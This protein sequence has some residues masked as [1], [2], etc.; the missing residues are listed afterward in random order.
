MARRA[1]EAQRCALRSSKR[2]GILI[3]P[4]SDHIRFQF[5]ARWSAALVAACK[6]TPGMSWNPDDAEDREDRTWVGYS[7]AIEVVCDKL[8]KDGLK[9]PSWRRDAHPQPKLP[10]PDYSQ[11]RDYQKTC[12]DFLITHAEQGALLAADMRLGKSLCALRAAEAISPENGIL[13]SAHPTLIICPSHVVGV[14]A[15]SLPTRPCEIKRWLGRN[16]AESTL[17]LE[18]TKP[19]L[20]H[21]DIR[22]R[23]RFVVIHFDILHAWAEVLQKVK[24]ITV[25]V[26]EIHAFQNEN[27]RRSQAGAAIMARAPF[28]IGLSGTPMTN[29]P[30]DLYSV[31]NILSPDRFGSNFF[32][33]GMSYCDGHK[34]TVGRGENQKVVYNFDGRSNAD[35]L[36]KR[37][38][39]FMLRVKKTDVM[40]QL[41]Q[42]ARQ[43]INVEIPRRNRLVPSQEHLKDK[44]L[45][46][47]LLDASADGKLPQALALLE[48]HATNGS[49]VIVFAYRRAVAEHL[50]NSLAA[51][52]IA[53]AVIHGGV[54]QRKREVL[55]EQARVAE[56]AF[57][58]VSTIDV[59]STGIDLSF[60]D[61]TVFVEYSWEPLDLVQAEE[62]TFSFSDPRPVLIQYLVA[63]GTADEFITNALIDKLD[64][65]DQIIGGDKSLATDLF[66]EQQGEEM[67]QS[68]CASLIADA[69]RKKGKKCKI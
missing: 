63:T 57:I 41:P 9:R 19:N 61:T 8:E 55:I 43:V 39:H 32:K 69:N 27:S 1:H 29:R 64:G 37:L 2:P 15:R 49:K 21:T 44:K 28:R 45:A 54:T 35:E 56:G 53:T 58:F 26:D 24:P 5:R 33:F 66:G 30:R 62:R 25:I 22:C 34:E 4:Y 36:R 10:A 38:K 50:A 20:T 13:L 67:L 59:G 12:I 17:I 40:D 6:S 16:A 18:G 31:G 60:A 52:D 7:D 51:K 14:W 68:F 48:E 3:E 23:Y 11:A 42:K 65:F 46:R 47:K